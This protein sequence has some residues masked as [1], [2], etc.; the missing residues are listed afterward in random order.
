MDNNPEKQYDHLVTELNN[1]LTE[2]GFAQV[3]TRLKR[4][5]QSLPGH[6]VVISS[7]ILLEWLGKQTLLPK[8]EKDS[9]RMYSSFRKTIREAKVDPN[10]RRMMVFNDSKYL[11]TFQCFTHF[12]FVYTHR[13]EF[14]MYVY[15]RS[16]DLVKLKDDLSF[17]AHQMKK[18]ERGTGYYV[19]KLV[20]VYGHL[21]IEIKKHEKNKDSKYMD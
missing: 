4:T 16:A 5:T 21:H 10:S 6:F 1:V 3:D 20:V 2:K 17:F 18:F 12:Q 9:K 7:P 8:Y 15:Q 11:S 19:T 14:D 13:N